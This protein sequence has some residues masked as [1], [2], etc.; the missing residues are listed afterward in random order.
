MKPISL[1]LLLAFAAT[2]PAVSQQIP[3]N[4]YAGQK[5]EEGPRKKT[6][7]SAYNSALR[8]IPDRKYDPWQGVRR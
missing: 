3:R 2:T 5:A 7:D 4:H 1:A 8:A 6:D